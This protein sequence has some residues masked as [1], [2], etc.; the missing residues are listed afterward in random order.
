M[1]DLD[2][3]LELVLVLGVV[4][5]LVYVYLQWRKYDPTGAVGDLLKF[6]ADWMKKFF[7]NLVAS[8]GDTLTTDTGDGSGTATIVTGIS[9]DGSY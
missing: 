9:S 1:K 2:N 4:G 3:F 6:V 8:D 5:L 7:A